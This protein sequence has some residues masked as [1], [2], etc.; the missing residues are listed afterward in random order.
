MK[1]ENF[2]KVSDLAINAHYYQPND[3][4][5]LRIEAVDV[6]EKFFYCL[7]ENTGEQYHVN[8]DEVDLKNDEFFQL[9]KIEK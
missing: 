9:K 6:D 4:D 7:D 1:N 3:T 8:F 5:M 2:Y